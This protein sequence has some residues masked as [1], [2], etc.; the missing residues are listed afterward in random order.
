MLPKYPV[1]TERITQPELVP[2][3]PKQQIYLKFL[4]RLKNGRGTR[5]NK[6]MYESLLSPEILQWNRYE[7]TR[8]K[9]M[10]E[11]ITVSKRS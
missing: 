1:G 10:E 2:L 4:Y 7:A 9:R 6:C 11:E 8:T 3:H 5:K